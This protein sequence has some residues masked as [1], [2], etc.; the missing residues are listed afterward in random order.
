MPLSDVGDWSL[1]NYRGHESN[2]DYHELLR[3]F[4]QSMCTRRLGEVYCLYAKR[5]RGYQVD[6]PGAEAERARAGHEGRRHA[7]PLQRVQ[8]LRR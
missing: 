6:P 1:Y 5:Y 8:A 2:A 7:D 3:E 4:L